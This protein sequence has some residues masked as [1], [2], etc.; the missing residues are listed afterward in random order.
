MKKLIRG[1]LYTVAVVLIG[2]I[3]ATYVSYR[4][5]LAK[6]VWY[7]PLTMNPEQMHQAAVSAQ[8]KFL[9]V[10][11]QAA[12]AHQAEVLAQRA[13]TLPATRPTLQVTFSSDELNAF[14]QNWAQLNGLHE[15]IN[16]YLADPQIILQ[17][18][19][20]ILAG[21]VK[22][23][24][25]LDGRV[26]SV[27]FRPVLDEDGQ[28]Q[29]DLQGVRA[30][31]LPLP[32]VLWDSKKGQLKQV[33]QQKLPQLRREAEIDAGGATNVPAMA[34]AMSQLA[35]AILDHRPADPI[36]FLPFD[37]KRNVPVKL[38]GVRVEEQSLTLQAV[39]LDAQQRQVLLKRIKEP[40]QTAGM[41]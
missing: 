33:L 21:T 5:S 11:N 36:V 6:P 7:R 32:A 18:G 24:E 9:T 37:Q 39:P 30:G 3:I 17:D 10:V 13:A 22:G 8:D 2:A 28:L 38:T 35:L 14:F 20:L 25:Q 1:I 12:S 41:Q 23:I 26:V 19:Q 34:A 16:R 15:R 40:V 4:L 31:R 29:M 27:H